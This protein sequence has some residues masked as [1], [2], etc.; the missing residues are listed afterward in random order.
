MG[1]FPLKNTWKLAEQLLYHEQFKKAT[2]RFVGE[3]ETWSHQKPHLWNGDTHWEASHK[4][5]AS[6]WEPRGSCPTLGILT[7]GICTR[8]EPHN[9]QLWKLMGLKFRRPKTLEGAEILLLR[10]CIHSLEVG[11]SSKA[12]VRKASRLYVKIHLLIL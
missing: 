5:G 9:V 8:D 2:L 3:V 1:Q 4:S 10:A 12:A 7:L 6:P 11:P